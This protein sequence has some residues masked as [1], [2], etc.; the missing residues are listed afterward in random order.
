MNNDY[1]WD[2]SG[3][4]D[5]EVQQLEEVLGTLRYQPQPLELPLDLQPAQ[6]RRWFPTLA[7]AATI[8]L[9]VL[10]ASVWLRFHRQQTS[11][12]VEVVNKPREQNNR[13]ENEGPPPSPTQVPDKLDVAVD[14]N[15]GGVPHR[16]Q[17]LPRR[18]LVRHI[19][20]KNTPLRR[21]E[22]R[23]EMT[24]SER[25]EGEAA[26]EQVMLALRVASTKL[27]HAQ[28]RTVGPQPTNNIRNQHKLG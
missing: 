22:I 13:K 9:L 5:P 7:I 26:K 14:K 25:A 16:N 1:L 19:E 18:Q 17:P 21:D 23:D 20:R 10:A 3:E 27:N 12:P 4:P 11:S 15:P 24:A 6:R 28:R 2:R 8:A